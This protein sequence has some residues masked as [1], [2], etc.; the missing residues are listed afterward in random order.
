MIP[1][2]PSI[3]LDGKIA[4]VTGAGAGIG[5]AIARAYAQLGA[6]VLGVEI[7]AARVATLAAELGDPHRVIQGDVRDNQSIADAF[8]ALEAMGDRLDVLVNNV[9]D[10]LRLRGGF[11]SF[12]SE[13]WDALYAINLRHVFSYTN[14]ALPHLRRSGQG[15][16]IINISTIEA[17]RG[18]PPAAVYAAFKAGITGFTRSIALKLGP[19][20]IRVN[21]IAPE[22]TETEQVP[23][24]P[25]DSGRTPPPHE[26]RDSDGALRGAYGR[27]RRGGLSRVQPVI[28]D[29]WNHTARGWRRTRR[30]K[31]LSRA[32]RGVD[33]LPRDY[34]NRCRLASAAARSVQAE[35]ITA[36][37]PPQ[38][39]PSPHPGTSVSALPCRRA[40]LP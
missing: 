30:R 5:R 13:S 16:S 35:A 28:L 40:A 18:A 37:S 26:S 8:G 17:Y 1:A 33:Q 38:A 23:G 15:G 22:T 2:A 3:R 20:Q 39:P 32:G 9:G 24:Q 11:D 31:L 36:T 12:S 6:T 29:D 4:L 10:N 14:A 19:E 25:H 7:D 21:I 27:C 34:R